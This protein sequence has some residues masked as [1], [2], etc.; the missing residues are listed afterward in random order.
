MYIY[1]S[2][3]LL[4]PCGN[5]RILGMKYNVSYNAQ[6]REVKLNCRPCPMRHCLH[7]Y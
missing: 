3:A 1:M 6:L 5:S 4:K 7:H 2:F